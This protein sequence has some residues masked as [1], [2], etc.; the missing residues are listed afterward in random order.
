MNELL[1]CPFCGSRQIVRE[2]RVTGHGDS[3]EFMCCQKCGACGP[4]DYQ[5]THTWNSRVAG[6]TDEGFPPEVPLTAAER[7]VNEKMHAVVKRF[8]AD[9]RKR[10]GLL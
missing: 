10:L 1:H 4:D 9:I 5:A 6:P 7:I 8:E 2:S 3:T